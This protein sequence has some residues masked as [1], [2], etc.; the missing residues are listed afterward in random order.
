MEQTQNDLFKSNHLPGVYP[1]CRKDG[2][3]YYRAS[4]TFRKKHISLGSYSTPKE[5]N[6][7]YD[8]ATH[9]LQDASI[10]IINY[11]SHSP[12]AFEKWVCLINFRDHGL[13]L[14]TPI[15]MG[16]KLFY[17]YLSPD[18]ILKFDLDDLFYYSSHK[19]MKRGNH[20]FVAEYGMQVNIV[21]RYGIKNYAVE[22]LDYRFINQDPTD[23]RREN[24]EIINIYHG[25]R[26]AIKNGHVLYTARI[27]VR[28]NLSIGSYNSETE[29]AIA[30]NKAVD[31]LKR[32]GITKNFQTNYIEG[33]SPR[34]Y[35]EIYS[36]L[37]ISS[38]V[39]NYGKTH[40]SE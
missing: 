30:Y 35:A 15:Y 10:D 24:I 9:L 23:F 19:I 22:G 36:N 25:V 38:V 18:H 6:Q 2:Q 32:N 1:A 8:E 14:G 16:Q 5:A 34:N 17:Y 29:A 33:M 26:K 28:G 39:E 21:N 40:F 37:S 31:I 7:A 27:H 20:Y 13:Y 11:S 4:L 3:V 12:L